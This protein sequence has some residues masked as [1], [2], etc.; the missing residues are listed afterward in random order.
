MSMLDDVRPA[1]A[2]PPSRTGSRIGIVI[3]AVVVLLGATGALGV[4]SRTSRHTSN[5][6][7]LSVTYAQVARSGLD[8]PW[9][10]RV[11]RDGGVNSDITLAVTSDYFRMFE[12]Q[13]F[14]PTPDSTT[15]DGDYVYMGFTKLMPGRDFVLDYDAYI[16]PASQIGKSGI[17]RLL[18]KGREM[19]RTSFHT[20][21]V[22]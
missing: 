21:L 14:Y 5:G 22:P 15:N 12:T 1:S 8:A 3:L 19:A 16:Q 2:G 18:V 6:Y 11:H 13:G 4:H 17:V 9:R 10:V 20:W 7:T